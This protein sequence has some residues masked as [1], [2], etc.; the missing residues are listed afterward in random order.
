M[1]TRGQF[2]RYQPI[3]V[4]HLVDRKRAALFAG[5]GTGKTTM[6]LTALD[7]LSLV[8][9]PFPA[10]VLAP[11][12]VARDGWPAEVEKWQHLSHLRVS[13]VIGDAKQRRD[14]LRPRC[15]IY[16]MNYENIPWLFEVLDG[17][18]PFRTV[19]ADES[20]KLQGFRL[21][22]GSKRAQILASGAR[23]CERWYNLT[24]KPA[25]N[26][27]EQLWGQTWFLDE[28]RRLGRSFRAFTDRWF[29]VGRDG[30]SL[31]PLPTAQQQIQDALHDLCLTIE[32][33][34]YFDLREP[35]HKTIRVKLPRDVMRV[36]RQIEHDFIAT[37]N[38]VEV[39]AANAAVKS[40]K[41][42]QMAS[43]AVFTDSRM[44]E[45]EHLHD[46]KIEALREV[47]E[48]AHGAP[49][50]VAY[51]WTHDRERLLRAFP[52]ARDLGTDDDA[53]RAFKRGELR[54][55]IAH[56][57]SLGHGTDG[58]QDACNIVCFFSQWW[59]LDHREQF[60]ERV[61]PMRQMQAGHDRACYVV[62]IVA[63]GTVDLAVL[64]RHALKGSVQDALLAYL[65]G[66]LPADER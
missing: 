25:P 22:Q 49:V 54:V 66:W 39:E 16:T 2:H 52:E 20:T 3:G 63:D 13:P 59:S 53:L 17:R 8:A 30:Y 61:G 32:G 31:T 36:Y 19:I 29:Q 55:G 10:L 47:I 18:W 6:A 57:Q 64:A 45:W 35:I 40:M 12:R 46:A 43:G 15:D 51:H 1:K 58:L 65:K 37:V 60:I 48:E 38:G 26:G 44:M 21:R 62:D 50:L 4:K 56:P 5:L 7:D 33:K 11:L 28:G 24:G 23:R 14:A 41:L 34:D 42:L 27:L 9:D